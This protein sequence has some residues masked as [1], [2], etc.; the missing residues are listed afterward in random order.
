M[1]AASPPD[2][3]LHAMLILRLLRVAIEQGS[4]IPDACEAVGHA[5]GGNS[6]AALE[7]VGGMLKRGVTW[8][9]AWHVGE[10][11]QTGFMPVFRAAL[12][13]SW[14]H[15]DAPSARLEAALEQMDSDE[16]A[17]IEQEGAHLS[18]QLLLPMGL[19]FLPAFIAVGVIP[20]I[21][22]FVA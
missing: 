13:P 19:C 20:S 6:G 15:G 5:V 7:Q 8:T 11:Q 22:S 14:L 9:D 12:E 16:R 1:T 10:R 2:D 21:A 4:S 17:A 3:A 18:V